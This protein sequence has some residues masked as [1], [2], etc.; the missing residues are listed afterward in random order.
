MALSGRSIILSGAIEGARRIHNIN[1]EIVC[2]S[3]SLGA[4]GLRNGQD[5]NKAFLMKIV[6]GLI[7]HPT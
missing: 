6:W 7:A 4:L 5:L 1:W 3:K 2:K